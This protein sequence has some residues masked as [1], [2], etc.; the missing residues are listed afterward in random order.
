MGHVD[1]CLQGREVRHSKVETG[2]LE[3]KTPLPPSEVAMETIKGPGIPRF[4]SGSCSWGTASP[5]PSEGDVRE[6][7]PFHSLP[8]GGSDW[9]VEEARCPPASSTRSKQDVLKGS[10]VW[11]GVGAQQKLGMFLTLYKR[12]FED[13]KKNYN[14]ITSRILIVPTRYHNLLSPAPIWQPN[15]LQLQ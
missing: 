1:S 10:L 15:K 2:L 7:L 6:A 13:D 12:S 11:E 3:V 5:P 4:C 8:E 14:N 9:S